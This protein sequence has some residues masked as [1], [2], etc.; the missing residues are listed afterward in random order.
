MAR[1]FGD[2]KWSH[3]Y[4]TNVGS[5]AYKNFLTKIKAEPVKYMK[6]IDKYPRNDVRPRLDCNSP[7]YECYENNPDWCTSCWG[8]VDGNK[9]WYLQLI[10]D[11]W[12]P[13]NNK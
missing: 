3:Q 4:G 13:A 8:D 6:G 2:V 12:N 11:L 7:C 10:V 5:T 9:K 1:D